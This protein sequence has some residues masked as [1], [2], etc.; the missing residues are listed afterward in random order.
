MK[1]E[2][3]CSM[4][5]DNR[6]TYNKWAQTLLVN[7]EKAVMQNGLCTTDAYHKRKTGGKVANIISIGQ[8]QI[9]TNSREQPNSQLHGRETG[10]LLEKSCTIFKNSSVHVWSFPIFMTTFP[11]PVWPQCQRAI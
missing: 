8:H 5:L 10:R 1:H 11:Q 6:A 9:Q 3:K 4:I 7:D 2:Q